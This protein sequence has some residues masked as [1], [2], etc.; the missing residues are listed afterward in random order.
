MCNA[1]AAQ[2]QRPDSGGPPTA[3]KEVLRLEKK[4]REMQ[5]IEGLVNAGERVDPQ[6]RQKLGR[7]AEVEAK[8]AEAL[9]LTACDDTTTVASHD[10]CASDG[11]PPTVASHDGCAF[12]EADERTQVDDAAHR[13]WDESAREQRQLACP[14]WQQATAVGGQAALAGGPAPMVQCLVPVQAQQGA[15]QLFCGA[16]WACGAWVPQALM[17]P[18]GASQAFVVVQQATPQ[19]ASGA[20]PWQAGAAHPRGGA[21][22]QQRH[23][24]CSG[25]AGDR[26]AAVQQNNCQR[27]LEG[28]DAGG[29]ARAS[30]LASLLGEVRR[31]AADPAGCRVVQRAL[32]VADHVSA[33]ELV[34][35]LHGHVRDLISVDFVARELRGCAAETARHR[36]GCRVVIRLIEHCA[37]TL[38]NA[39][40]AALVE[41]LLAEVAGLCRHALGHHVIKAIVEH[42]HPVQ[43]QRVLAFLC[44]GAA[45]KARNHYHCYVVEAALDICAAEHAEPLALALVGST[46]AN[47]ISL[48]QARCGC[49]VLRALLRRPGAASQKA[50]AV[51]ATAAHRLRQ[52]PDGQRLLRD[53]GLP[54]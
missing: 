41:E 43:Q 20:G 30:A 34:Q 21:P 7:R 38:A 16:V 45:D 49:N 48:S 19:A 40:R 27:L 3:T 37:D 22:P 44:A 32:E 8:L 15:Q 6:Q 53:A 14:G 24:G 29:P 10:G 1:E 51:L 11:S 23:R 33:A 36:Y 26:E 31:L 46:Q 5:K 42:A 12:Q 39:G 47:V 18:M 50:R 9:R 28:L 35:D 4:L 54:A 17:S 25:R 13:R 2:A 52:S